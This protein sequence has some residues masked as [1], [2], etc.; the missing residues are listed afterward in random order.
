MRLTRVDLPTLG[1]PT[2]ATIGTATS[3][4][5][6]RS[7]MGHPLSEHDVDEPVDNL[8]DVEFGGVQF[9]R[10]VGLAQ[11]AGGPPAVPARS[12]RSMSA[13]TADTSVAGP[14]S[15]ARRRARVSALAV[16]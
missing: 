16:R 14:R 6:T 15:P 2:T 4:S 9:D 11:G 3:S 10:A 13:A 7:V 1:R 12:R 5:S 8:L